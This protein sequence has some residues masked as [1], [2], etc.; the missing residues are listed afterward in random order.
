LA[1]RCGTVAALRLDS[2][3]ELARTPGKLAVIRKRIDRIEKELFMFKNT[4]RMARFLAFAFMLSAAVY[5]PAA[6]A[7]AGSNLAAAYALHAASVA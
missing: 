6:I 4:L 1:D 5:T 7:A 2:I 3:N